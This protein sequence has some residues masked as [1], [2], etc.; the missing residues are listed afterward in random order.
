MWHPH[1]GHAE[2]TLQSNAIQ[3]SGSRLKGNSGAQLSENENREEG[4]ESASA[5]GTFV[6][7]ESCPIVVARHIARHNFYYLPH[8]QSFASPALA[9]LSFPL[10]PKKEKEIL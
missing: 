1:S 9:K 5:C 6:T 3:P 4:K 10:A 8:L 2:P 7:P